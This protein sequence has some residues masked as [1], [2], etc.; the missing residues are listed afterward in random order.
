MPAAVSDL[1]RFGSLVVFYYPFNMAG[2]FGDLAIANVSPGQ[3]A[4]MLW[5]YGTGVIINAG[6]TRYL[7]SLVRLGTTHGTASI[8]PGPASP[9][10]EQSVN[11]SHSV[12]TFVSLVRLD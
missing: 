9:R 6:E 1:P 3:Q 4:V 12:S 11:A 5:Y 8:L 7:P 2:Q 10:G